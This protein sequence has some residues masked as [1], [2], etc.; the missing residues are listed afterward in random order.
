MQRLTKQETQTA[1]QTQLSEKA[2]L[3]QMLGK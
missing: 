3:Q 1:T 2:Q